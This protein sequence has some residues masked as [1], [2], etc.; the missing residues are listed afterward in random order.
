MINRLPK[1]FWLPTSNGGH[2]RPTNGRAAT[3]TWSHRISDRAQRCIGD[4]PVASLGVAFLAGLL[5][6]GVFKR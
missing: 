3:P 6:G 1:S 5:V 2:D 4:H